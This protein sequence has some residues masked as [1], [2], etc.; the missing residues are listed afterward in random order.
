MSVAT[1]K[2]KPGEDL[3]ITVQDEVVIPPPPVSNAFKDHFIP[4]RIEAEDY[5]KGGENVG[6]H[7][8][9]PENRGGQYRTDGVDIERGPIT[10]IGYMAKGE[11]TRYTLK[12]VTAGKY[13]LAAS[14]S[15]ITTV[16]K[17]TIS[18]DGKILATFT[19]PNTGA[20]T[21]YRTLTIDVDVPTGKVLQLD[22]LEGNFNIDYFEFANFSVPPVPPTTGGISSG[23][24]EAIR[25]AG[26][27][28]TVLFNKG[29]YPI[30]QIN[31][32][33]GVSVDLG[34]S[35]L[36]GTVPGKFNEDKP[37]FR[38]NGNQKFGNGSI[39]GKNIISSCVTASGD[40]IEID[41]ITGTECNFLGAWL[42]D[43][44]NSKLT[45]FNFRNCSGALV[46]WAAG[47]VCFRNL[48]NV[49]IAYGEVSSDSSTRGYGMKAMYHDGSLKGVKMHHV[50]IDMN[51]SSIWNNNQS[52]NIGLEIH[53]TKIT[54][55]EVYNCEFYNQVSLSVQYQGGLTIFRDN[56]FDVETDTYLIEYILDNLKFY[57]NTCKNW[58]TIFA[59]FKA[60][61]YK[62]AN[63]EVYDNN[64]ILPVGIPSWAGA[65]YFGES[66]VQNFQLK[67][68]II[69]LK[70]GQV[71]M[72]IKYRRDVGGVIQSGNTIKEV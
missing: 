13:K 50:K 33:V 3:I 5:D 69:E 30:G 42:N 63:A 8:L 27:G 9:D 21:S 10:N 1:L 22:V 57:R 2:K 31:V 45:N 29:T 68:N 56:Y 59:N 62:W 4:G 48:N 71:P 58:Q 15:S 12:T 54:D 23:F 67:N 37:M 49:E 55:V 64:F 47:E 46:S 36:I 11:W 28:K 39:Q 43:V 6:Y 60:Q 19:V 26:I 61:P 44:R 24:D 25:T 17:F 16:G 14:V 32:P 35:T 52:K 41:K 40:G 18:I 70:R 38:L 72:L 51:H 66:G 53:Q 34:G 65:F 20:W 7:D